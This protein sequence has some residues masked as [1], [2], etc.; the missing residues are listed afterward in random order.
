[1]DGSFT[2]SNVPVGSQTLAISK[3]GY[4]SYSKPVNITAG[5]NLDAGDSYLK[6]ICDPANTQIGDS[7]DN[8]QILFGTPGVDHYC[9]YGFGGNDTQY[10]EA[11]LGGD[12]TFQDGGPGDDHQT[13]IAGDGN[14][15]LIQYGGEGKD[16]MYAEGGFGEKTIFQDGGPGDDNMEIARGAVGALV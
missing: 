6:P 3:T 16:T 7:G 4:Q 9:Q 11:D 13:A 2:L 10:V 15:S 1:M 8:E 5:Q 12:T 14:D